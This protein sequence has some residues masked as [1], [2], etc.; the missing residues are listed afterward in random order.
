MDA[1]DT[2]RCMLA[3][4]EQIWDYQRQL[5]QIKAL[6]DQLKAQLPQILVKGEAIT[7]VSAQPTQS[8][9]ESSLTATFMPEARGTAPSTK[10]KPEAK[11]MASQSTL[12]PEANGAALQGTHEPEA[13]GCIILSFYTF[14]NIQ[15]LNSFCLPCLYEVA[16]FQ[17][18]PNIWGWFLFFQ[19]WN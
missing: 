14:T 5:Y 12:K 8:N 18:T 15:M 17:S 3:Q 16:C 2:P 11:S 9:K 4:N 10:L 19:A 1:A 13:N 7:C 6:L